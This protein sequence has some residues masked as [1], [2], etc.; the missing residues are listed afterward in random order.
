[1]LSAV[2]VTC[3][4]AS[5]ITIVNEGNMQSPT[6]VYGLA[7]KNNLQGESKW[8]QTATCRDAQRAFTDTRNSVMIYDSTVDFRERVKGSTCNQ[9][10][11]TLQNT[12][13]ISPMPVKFCHKTGSTKKITDRDVRMGIASVAATRRHE[14]EWNT[15]GFNVRFVA[16]GGSLGVAQAT[17]N[18]EVDWGFIAAPVAS[19]QEKLGS[20]QCPYTTD[21]TSPNFIGR[22]AIQLS[23]PDFEII[24][25]VYTNSTDPL[26]M[27]RLRDAATSTDFRSY[28]ASSEMSGITDITQADVDKVNRLVD[29]LVKHWGD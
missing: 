9:A 12:V 3:V 17:A 1:M 5:E 22:I 8:V 24:T 15:N 27:R 10:L 16:Y 4:A 28:L 18:G 6:A 21:P 26:V 23:V 25:A 20:I 14:R 19:K 29:R 11:I 2:S 7:F 13:V